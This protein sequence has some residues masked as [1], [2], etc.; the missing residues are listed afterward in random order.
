MSTDVAEAT[1]ADHICIVL[2]SCRDDLPRFV[3]H[4]CLLQVKKG[5]LAEM[6]PMLND[7][8]AVPTWS[9]VCFAP[10]VQPAKSASSVPD[11]A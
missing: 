8:S 4:D 5:P 1:C 2:A 11:V 7:I 9:K 3:G 10:H 6:S